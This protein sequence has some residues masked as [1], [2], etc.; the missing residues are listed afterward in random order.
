MA[1]RHFNLDVC[2]ACNLGNLGLFNLVT[3]FGVGVGVVST[4]VFIIA[5]IVG[6][7]C[8]FQCLICFR[9]RIL[10]GSGEW[11][12]SSTFR[13]TFDRFGQLARLR[14]IDARVAGW[15][16]LKTVNFNLTNVGMG[17]L[18]LFCYLRSVSIM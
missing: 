14:Q 17:K 18:G 12:S 16:S 10:T 8:L 15:V 9:S 6:L 5:F 1:G 4:V 2:F 3:C 13:W 7:L 11:P